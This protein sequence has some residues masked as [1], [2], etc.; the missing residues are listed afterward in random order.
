M[1]VL[2]VALV[3][4]GFVVDQRL[5]ELFVLSVC[6][7]LAGLDGVG[8]LSL[9]ARERLGDIDAVALRVQVAVVL[10]VCELSRGECA[11]HL[12]LGQGEDTE[13]V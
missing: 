1:L 8:K 13:V 3:D 5:G 2:V 4:A 6:Q 9:G 11:E 12:Q 7:V 10:L